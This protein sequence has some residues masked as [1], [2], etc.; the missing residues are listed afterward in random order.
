[1]TSQKKKM[2]RPTE[3]PKNHQTRIRMTQ[4]EWDRL[5]YCAKSMNLTKTDVINMSILKLFEE[6]QAE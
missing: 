5:D 6:I 4:D 2:G 3:N 1:M